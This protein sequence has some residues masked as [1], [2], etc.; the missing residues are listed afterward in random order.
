MYI[1][2]W[3]PV[4]RSTE[5]T[6]QA[7]LR[8]DLMGLRFVAFRDRQGHAAVLSDTCIH[9]GGALGLGKVQGDCIECPYHGW[10]FGADGR[11]RLIPT[12]GGAAPP[13]RA[14]VDGYPVEER[15]GIVFAFL[16]DL[17][18]DQRPPPCPVPEFG[19]DGWRA[20][21]IVEFEVGCY[22]ERSMENGLDPAHNQFVHPGQGFPPMLT[23]TLETAEEAWGARFW[24]RFGDP[25]LDKTVFARERNRTGELKA[26]SW[27]H[28]PNNLVTSIFINADSN[29]VQYFFEAP[30]SGDRTRIFF[31]NMRNCMLDEGMDEQVMAVNRKIIG[32]DVRILESLWPL[33]TPESLNR[34]LMSAADHTVVSYREW[35]RSFEARGWRIDRDAMRER[36][37]DVA[38]AIPCPARRESGS[39]VLEPVPLVSAPTS[40]RAN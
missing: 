24:M 10:Q 37:G 12:L 5:L 9:R 29:M 31:L 23:D 7:P 28:G 11:C 4:C 22:Y 32:E 30:V 16:G 33:R 8:V 25:Q 18:A 15:Y 39:W 14:K 26:G 21:D 3:Y 13:A 19:E 36:H 20:S 34:E 6:A 38:W 1:N 35:L 17:P 27:F 2:F 40:G